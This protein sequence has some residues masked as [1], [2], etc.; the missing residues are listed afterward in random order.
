[1]ESLAD[2]STTADNRVET[3]MQQIQEHQE[4]CSVLG[5]KLHA[6]EGDQLSD[7]YSFMTKH[8][9]TDFSQVDASTQK[10][11]MW[12]LDQPDFYAWF[13]EEDASVLMLQQLET[14]KASI[15]AEQ[16]D[17][18][19]K[20]LEASRLEKINRLKGIRKSNIETIL[21]DKAYSED[22]GASSSEAGPAPVLQTTEVTLPVPEPP[23]Q[24]H[25]LGRFAGSISVICGV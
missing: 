16:E 6:F 1:M 20:K 10:R 21:E 18:V 14:L 25:A 3:L 7:V 13:K 9:D 19:Q 12:Y 22:T 5:H 15:A 17:D 23:P 8:T 4:L 24:P 11:Y 2:S